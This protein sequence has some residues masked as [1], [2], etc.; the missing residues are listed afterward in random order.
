MH[1]ESTIQLMGLTIGEGG[2]PP[3]TVEESVAIRHFS[4]KAQ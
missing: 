2:A 1:I 4:A 3:E